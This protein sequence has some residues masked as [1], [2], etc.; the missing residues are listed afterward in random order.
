MEEE[1]IIVEAV[2]EEETHVGKV[3]FPATVPE[4]L[5]T[6]LFIPE[7]VVKYAPAMGLTSHDTRF[8]FGALKGK[9]G[10]NVDLNLPDLAPRLG[11]SFDEIDTIV[12]SLLEKNY[13]KY[14]DRL[15]FYRFWIVIL[16][17]KGIRFDIH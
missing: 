3:S 7:D 17:L 11:L 2:M 6:Y 13:V 14:D 12:R 10:L 15:N 4:G 16:H 1:T 9:W 8:I 5:A